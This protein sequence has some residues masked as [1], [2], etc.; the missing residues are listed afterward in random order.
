MPGKSQTQSPQQHEVS[1]LGFAEERV[2]ARSR[3]AGRPRS[4]LVSVSSCSCSFRVV[5]AGIARRLMTS[6]AQI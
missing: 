6:R 1:A 4:S 2:G 3:S 5:S